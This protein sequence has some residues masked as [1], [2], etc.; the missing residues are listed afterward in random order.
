[1][2]EGKKRTFFWTQPKG[3]KLKVVSDSKKGTLK[4][5]NDKGEKIFERKDLSEKELKIVEEN[6]LSIVCRK[7]K[8]IGKNLRTGKNDP[9]I[10]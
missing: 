9:M 5:F 7:V 8:N 4:V 10:A 3:N 6:F 2:S 1:M